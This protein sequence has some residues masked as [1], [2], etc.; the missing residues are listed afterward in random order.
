[1]KLI[2]ADAII[3]AL[4]SFSDRAHGN[5]HFLNGIETAKELIAEADETVVRC[6]EC[7]YW[8]DQKDG[9]VEVP[10]C[11]YDCRGN[12]RGV[13]IVMGADDFCS[14][15]ERRTNETD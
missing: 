5:Q 15:G 9:V 1:M 4:E 3:A 7:I 2:N 13:V 6:E 11:K 14:H 12:K 10:V 8:Q